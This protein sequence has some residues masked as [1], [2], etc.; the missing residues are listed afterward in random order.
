MEYPVKTRFPPEPNGFLHI[1]HAKAIYI[2]FMYAKNNN[3]I[4]YLRFDD[5][6]PKTEKQVY[7]DSIIEDVKWLGF[8]PYKITYTS[9]YFD[10]LYEYA[11]KLIENDKC[12]V[13][14]LDS[15][16]ISNGRKECLDSPYRNRPINESLKLFKEMAEGKHLPGSM[17][18]RMK[19]DM[20]S[21]NPNMRDMVAYRIIF[22]DHHRTGNKCK[23]YPSYDFSHPI[24]D[25]LEGIT[26][27]FCSMEF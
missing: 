8:E 23:V 16:S 5:T 22:E 7:I 4:C 18:L 9:D 10:R 27:S 11:I 12:Y 26:H 3:G 15:E 14:E 19:C 13:C 21:P 1:G 20:K 2:N 17:V 24:V 6:N 25:S